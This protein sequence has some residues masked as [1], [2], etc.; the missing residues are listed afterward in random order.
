MIDAL[1]VGAFVIYALAAGLRARRSASRGLE[2]YF[3][4]DRRL[5]AW[6]SGL[7]MTA[8]QYAADTPLLAAG[9]VTAFYR[10]QRRRTQRELETVDD[11][12]WT[13]PKTT[14]TTK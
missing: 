4:A 12:P 13:A 8:T 5:P 6:Q 7:S 9:L 14:E 1:L 3:L 2:S 11:T 10:R